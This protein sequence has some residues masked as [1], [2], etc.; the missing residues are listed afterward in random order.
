MRCLEV[1]DRKGQLTA[2]EVAAETGLTSGAVTAM[3]DRL[4][5]ADLVRRQPDPTDRRRVLVEPTARAR[6]KVA[7]IYGPFTTEL[8]EFERYSD[9]QLRLITRFLKQASEILG[10]QTARVEQQTRDKGP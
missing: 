1:L 8:G 7:E 3:L 9:E 10:R 6:A 4:A 5:A 2:G